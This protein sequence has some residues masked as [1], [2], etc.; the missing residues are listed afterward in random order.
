VEIVGSKCTVRALETNNP[1]FL[2]W[3]LYFIQKRVQNTR[4]EES[5]QSD[6]HSPPENAEDLESRYTGFISNRLDRFDQIIHRGDLRVM[7]DFNFACVE[8]HFGVSYS[9]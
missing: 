4:R 5:I 1:K 2:K 8:I 9:I 7:L 3:H 6:P